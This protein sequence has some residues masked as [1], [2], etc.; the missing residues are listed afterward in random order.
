MGDG[1][2]LRRLGFACPPYLQQR[3]IFTRQGASRPWPGI[4]AGKEIGHR[5]L[6]HPVIRTC[7]PR[8]AGNVP[9]AFVGETWRA[10]DNA[11]FC[12]RRDLNGYYASDRNYVIRRYF[13]PRPAPSGPLAGVSICPPGGAHLYE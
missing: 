12:H 9:E 1:L 7:L 6:I 2:L 13:T 4:G 8:R 3:V 11:D 5:R 10:S